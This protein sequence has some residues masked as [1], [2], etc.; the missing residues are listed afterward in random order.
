M[1]KSDVK[2][3]ELEVRNAFPGSGSVL[4]SD[5]RDFFIQHTPLTTEQAFRRFLYRL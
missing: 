2:V 5:L 3:D 4:K 1:R